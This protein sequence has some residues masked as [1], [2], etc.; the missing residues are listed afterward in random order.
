MKVLPI[1]KKVRN[2]TLTCAEVAELLADQPTA[3]GTSHAHMHMADGF[4][5]DPYK[6]VENHSLGLDGENRGARRRDWGRD[7]AH[8]FPVAQS[9]LPRFVPGAMTSMSKG[10]VYMDPARQARDNSYNL[11]T[12]L[13]D[14]P[15]TPEVVRLD[16]K[17]YVL[18]L[19]D[20]GRGQ[21]TKIEVD[22]PAD[23]PVPGGDTSLY[24]MNG[25]N[26]R[27]IREQQRVVTAPAT[28]R[29]PATS[30]HTMF[31]DSESMVMHVT[32]ALKSDA[33]REVLKT[34]LLRGAGDKQTVGI[35]SKTAIRAVGSKFSAVATAKGQAPIPSQMINRVADAGAD[36]VPTGT[37]TTGKVAFDHIVLVLAASPDF[38]LV[39]VTSFPTDA[40]TAASIGCPTSADQ[41]I[42]EHT[43]GS[44][45]VMP[46]TNPLPTLTW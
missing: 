31:E 35:F 2:G 45:T 12:N 41:D 25:L 21:P 20:S 6:I 42:A 14:V 46:V 10:H 27:V 40:T 33:G 17:Y 15:A 5:S 9:K 13:P 38:D 24:V 22:G 18:R 8:L 29:I 16:P 23:A 4:R 11:R 32:A 7:D 19:P 1:F 44:H 26:R 28:P 34:L 30:A 39:V 43:F 37:F 36:R 3:D